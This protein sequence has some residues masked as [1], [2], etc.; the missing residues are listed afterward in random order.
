LSCHFDVLEV[1]KP[2]T[3]DEFAV[4]GSFRSRK[5]Q[6]LVGEHSVGSSEVKARHL[7]QQLRRNRESGNLKGCR[8]FGAGRSLLPGAERVLLTNEEAKR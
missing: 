7:V 6:H 3:S 2:E 5:E 1:D 8:A 4:G